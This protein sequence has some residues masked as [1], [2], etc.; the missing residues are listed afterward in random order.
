VRG[1][2]AEHLV[3]AVQ[4]IRAYNAAVLAS[5][6]KKKLQVSHKCLLYPLSNLWVLVLR[7]YMGLQ[8]GCVQMLAT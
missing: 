5:E 1:R 6:S 2:P 3:L 4:R 8:A 7:Q